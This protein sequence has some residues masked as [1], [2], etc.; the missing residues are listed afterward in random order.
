MVVEPGMGDACQVHADTWTVSIAAPTGADG[1]GPYD[2]S[3]QNFDVDCMAVFFASTKMVLANTWWLVVPVAFHVRAPFPSWITWRSQFSCLDRR[4]PPQAR[5][6][7]VTHHT[8]RTIEESLAIA[9]PG[10]IPACRDAEGVAAGRLGQ[11]IHRVGGATIVFVPPVF[12]AL[13]RRVRGHALASAAS[14]THRS[15]DA[16]TCVVVWTMDHVLNWM[17][18]GQ[19]SDDTELVAPCMAVAHLCA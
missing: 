15:C 19:M 4:A 18:R 6:A 16:D 8:R 2:R 13:A 7:S 3:D 14:L 10:R 17:R 11:N 5:H 12:G 1:I 9:H